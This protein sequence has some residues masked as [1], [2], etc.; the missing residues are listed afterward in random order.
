[1]LHFVLAF[2]IFVGNTI[3]APPNTPL[4]GRLIIGGLAAAIYL[5]LTGIYGILK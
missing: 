2:G 3:F 5:V 1:M 4:S